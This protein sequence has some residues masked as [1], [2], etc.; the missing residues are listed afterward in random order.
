MSE[1]RCCRWRNPQ[2]PGS[3]LVLHFSL[4]LGIGADCIES[5]RENG[6]VFAPATINTDEPIRSPGVVHVG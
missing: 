6:C 2:S 1:L 5:I 3:A 4:T